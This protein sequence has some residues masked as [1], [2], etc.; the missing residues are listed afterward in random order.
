MRIDINNPGNPAL[1]QTG[2]AAETQ[3]AGSSG[4]GSATPSSSAPADGL[5]LSPFAGSLSQ[6][7]RGDSPDRSQ[8]VAQ[9]TEAVQS[10][11]YR[12]DAKAVSS[13]I[14]DYAIA[15]DRSAR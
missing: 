9:L 15:A 12:V 13:R 3:S 7:I 10:G 2:Q 6:V 8:R 4:K 14:V 11:T 5:R 1:G